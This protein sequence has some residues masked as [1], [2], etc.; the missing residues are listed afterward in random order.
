MQLNKLIKVLEQ[1]KLKYAIKHQCEAH[2]FSICP[3]E[4]ILLCSAIKKENGWR[5]AEKPYVYVKIK[6]LQRLI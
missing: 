1:A 5:K 4:G 3:D 2:I 6:E